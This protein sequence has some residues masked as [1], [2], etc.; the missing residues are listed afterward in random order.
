[1]I[2]WRGRPGSAPADGVQGYGTGSFSGVA[3]F[4]DP[5]GTGTGVFGASGN[6]AN[7][8]ASEFLGEVFI[9]GI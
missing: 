6:A 4:G 2:V 7:E 5:E 9:M 3:G 8:L 1:M